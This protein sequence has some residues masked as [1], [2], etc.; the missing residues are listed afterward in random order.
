MG[1]SLRTWSLVL[2]KLTLLFSWFPQTKVDSKPPSKKETTRRE[3]S[4]V[5]PAST[6][7]CSICWVSSKSLLVLTKWTP[8]SQSH[9]VKTDSRKLIRKSRRC[10]PRLV[11]KPRRSHSFQCPDSK[12]TASL[13]NLPTWTGTKDSK[14]SQKRKKLKEKLFLML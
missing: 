6:H 1:I 2:P 10:L 9:T 5:K 14:S 7:D 12:E 3:K 13:K 11:S 4:K 8:Q